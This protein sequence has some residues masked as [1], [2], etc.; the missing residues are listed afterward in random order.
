M[1]LLP[2]RSTNWSKPLET[3]RRRSALIMTNC[4]RF[5]VVLI[6]SVSVISV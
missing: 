3:C 4:W 2:L 6:S 1:N 5:T